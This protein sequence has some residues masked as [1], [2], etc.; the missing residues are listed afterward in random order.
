L[1]YRNVPNGLWQDS[2]YVQFRASA[3]RNRAGLAGQG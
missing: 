3:F 1:S 2:L